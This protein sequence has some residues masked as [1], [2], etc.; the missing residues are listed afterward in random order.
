M[1][2]PFDDESGSF[3]VLVN[4]EKQY[5]LWPAPVAVPDGWEVA[6]GAAPRGE[7]LEF[8]NGTWTDMR[9]ASLVRAMDAS[10]S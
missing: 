8:I 10:G 1:E 3:Y 6:H 4:E 2:N 7:C 5:S 9:P